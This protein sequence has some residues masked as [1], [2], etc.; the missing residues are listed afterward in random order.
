MALT[1]FYVLYSLERSSTMSSRPHLEARMGGVAIGVD[2]NGGGAVAGED[3][4]VDY[5]GT[6]LI[7]KR[8][9]PRTTIGP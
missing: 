2:A 6:S 4:D 1:V 9:P 5:R 8:N 7:R 3:R